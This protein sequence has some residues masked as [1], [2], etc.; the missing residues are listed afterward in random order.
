[1]IDL[2]N[3]Y[4]FLSAYKSSNGKSGFVSIKRDASIR[5]K[6]HEPPK[7]KREE[8]DFSGSQRK[9]LT[10]REK[11]PFSSPFLAVTLK[12]PLKESKKPLLEATQEKSPEIH[13]T[14]KKSAKKIIVN[15]SLVN[16]PKSI[17]FN[18]K[19]LESTSAKSKIK[20]KLFKDMD[21]PKER[22]LSP[23]LELAFC[24]YGKLP[25]LQTSKRRIKIL[26]YDKKRKKS[27]GSKGK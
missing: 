5:K 9:S 6:S 18:G 16:S 23:Y 14:R 17:C 22:A 3:V 24:S 11:S 21:N 1:M 10:F 20:A 4:D 15:K 13:I 26:K 7:Q 19:L 12:P 8:V 2:D 27:G 25:L